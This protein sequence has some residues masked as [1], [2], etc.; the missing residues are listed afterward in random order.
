MKWSNGL[1]E[2]RGGSRA[3]ILSPICLIFWRSVE[4]T[5]SPVTETMAGGIG[6][7]VILVLAAIGV[8]RSPMECSFPGMNIW[9]RKVSSSV[10][11]PGVIVVSCRRKGG[12]GAGF[13]VSALRSVWSLCIVGVVPLMLAA[14]LSA[15]DMACICCVDILLILIAC[16]VFLFIRWE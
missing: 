1:R 11:R 15:G 16:A 2:D 10:W 12:A 14:A 13:S 7:A 8:A 9:K 6:V 4:L 3:L 5:G